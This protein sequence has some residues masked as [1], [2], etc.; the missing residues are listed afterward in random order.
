MD[1]SGALHEGLWLEYRDEDYFQ[2]IDYKQISFH[3]RKCHEHCHLIKEC[4]LNKAA[5]EN[6]ENKGEKNK[7]VFTR[8]KAKQRANKKRQTKAST[9]HGNKSNAFEVLEIE[10]ESEDNN[11]EQDTT[12]ISRPTTTPERN[13]PV[14][15]PS[16]ISHQVQE[17]TKGVEEDSEMFTNEIGL[18]DMELSDMLEQEGMDLPNMVE[19]WKKKGMEHISEEEVKRI[20][21]IFIA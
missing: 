15:N 14:A 21:D 20:N 19:N 8:P 13:E 4:S 12:T 11:K 18:E 9:S 17:T 6:K 3:C 2:A 5:G 10:T 1:V 16:N 7:E